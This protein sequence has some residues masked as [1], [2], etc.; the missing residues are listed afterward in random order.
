MTLHDVAPLPVRRV[1]AW[2]RILVAVDG[3]SASRAALRWVADHLGAAHGQVLIVCVVPDEPA[4]TTEAEAELHAAEVVLSTLLDD[5]EIATQLRRGAAVDQ[6]ALAADEFEADLLVVGTHATL[7]QPKSGRVTVAGRLAA[8]AACTVVVVPARWAP[9]AGPIV[10]G[11]SIDSASAEALDVAYDLAERSGRRLMI[12][13]VWDPPA[14]GEI[15]ITPGGSE[16]IPERQ[17]VALD[18]LVGEFISRPSTVDVRADLRHGDVH[19]ELVAAAKGAALIVV[20]RRARSA[21]A[22]LIL[23]STSRALVSAPPCPVAV[24]PAPRPGI[25]VIPETVP[26]EL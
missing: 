6:L 4:I 21:A 5:C 22:Q 2:E 12:T 1:P 17:R 10:A 18:A 16:S 8:R 14:V 23:G 9:T 19:R 15:A 25:P 3:G 20:G 7:D 13:H 26:E 11:S 24:V